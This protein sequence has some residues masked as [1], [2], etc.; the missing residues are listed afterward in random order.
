[1]NIVVKLQLITELRI[2][3][4]CKHKNIIEFMKVEETK[5]SIFIVTEYMSGGNLKNFIKSRNSNN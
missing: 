1:M 5:N 3:N 4:S 2:L